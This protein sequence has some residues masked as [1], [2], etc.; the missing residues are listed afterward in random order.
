MMT[1]CCDIVLMAHFLVWLEHCLEHFTLEASKICNC[2]QV[3][4]RI[5]LNRSSSNVKNLWPALEESD[6]H[7]FLIDWH[8]DLLDVLVCASKL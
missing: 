4:Q 3:K 8:A 1:V 5:G 6:C 7:C 2:D